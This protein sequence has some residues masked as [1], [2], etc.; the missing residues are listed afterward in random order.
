MP[1]KSILDYEENLI[2]AEMFKYKEKVLKKM[3]KTKHIND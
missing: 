1:S 2:N 3:Y